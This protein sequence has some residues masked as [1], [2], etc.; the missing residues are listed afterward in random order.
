M[1]IFLFFPLSLALIS[2]HLN[3]CPSLSLY[4]M[5]LYVVGLLS[6]SHFRLWYNA[7]QTLGAKNMSIYSKKIIFRRRWTNK[8]CQQIYENLRVCILIFS[9]LFIV[10]FFTQQFLLGGISSLSLSFIH[11]VFFLGQIIYLFK[12]RMAKVR[13]KSHHF[14]V[15][16]ITELPL[17]S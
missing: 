17:P 10:L 2:L 13:Q 6:S 7:Q 16:L 12:S 3:I 8:N 1:L 15:I 11:F 5:V 9:I 4:R 14:K